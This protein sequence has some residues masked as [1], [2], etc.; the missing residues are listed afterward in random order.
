M[1]SATG[2]EA[3]V[4]LAFRTGDTVISA[5]SVTAGTD[6]RSADIAINVSK[7]RTV[8]L[9]RPASGAHASLTSV[10]NGSP[11]RRLRTT[12]KVL[13]ASR[14]CHHLER[15]RMPLDEIPIAIVNASCRAASPETD[16][17]PRP[18]ARPP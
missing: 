4:Y 18:A 8:W 12:P 9:A 2:A 14:R 7:A 13:I 1:S 15:R 11:S 3:H 16:K 6:E 17:P 10:S 5:S